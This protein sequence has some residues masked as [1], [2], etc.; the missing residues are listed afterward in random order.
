MCC[1]PAHADR[2]PSLSVTIGKRAILLHCFAG[3]ANEDVLRGFAQAGIKV[4]DLFNGSG[5]PIVALPRDETPN[6]NALRLWRE[7]EV[8][9]E[10]Y[11]TLDTAQIWYSATECVDTDVEVREGRQIRFVQPVEARSLPLTALATTVVPQFLDSA[12]Y[13]ELLG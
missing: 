6:R 7:V 4:A 8:F 1:C 9:H 3:C 5:E 2:T 12:E 11:G 10:A 13:G